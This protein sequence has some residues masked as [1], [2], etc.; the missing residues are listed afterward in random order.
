MTTSFTSSSFVS[1]R[2][3]ASQVISRT[4][5]RKPDPDSVSSDASRSEGKT[6]S[7][8]V[9]TEAQRSD[10]L[11]AEFQRE[12]CGL[13]SNLSEDDL[14]NQNYDAVDVEKS[15]RSN[16]DGGCCGTLR[17]VQ[18]EVETGSYEQANCIKV[19]EK[20]LEEQESLNAFCCEMCHVC[21]P[22]KQSSRRVCLDCENVSSFNEEGV[23][24]ISPLNNISTVNNHQEYQSNQLDFRNSQTPSL[25]QQSPKLVPPSHP[26]QPKIS[27]DLSLRVDYEDCSVVKTSPSNRKPRERSHSNCSDGAVVVQILDDPG[28][29]PML[30]RYT[31]PVRT[32]RGRKPVPRQ[33]PRPASKGKPPVNSKKPFVKKVSF[34]DTSEDV[35]YFTEL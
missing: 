35:E 2:R 27:P 26:V 3:R 23:S 1:L 18:C 10:T 29:S 8:T 28:S 25:N 21:F 33:L 31:K 5:Y 13:T 15:S 34:R 11:S 17:M 14:Q 30:P 22:S 16:L 9:S 24:E 6:I 20:T 7:S 32:P 4:L 12:A 19:G